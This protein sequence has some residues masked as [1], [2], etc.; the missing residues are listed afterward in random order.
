M[1]RDQ[2]PRHVFV[3]V[4]F[5]LVAVGFSFI[6]ERSAIFRRRKN[7]LDND[8]VALSFGSV[9]PDGNVVNVPHAGPETTLRL[10]GD[11][12]FGYF[13]VVGR[14]VEEWKAFVG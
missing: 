4:G 8:A 14:L 11:V 9:S 7:A 1:L 5:A 13:E 6:A 12:F 2:F 10:D 3:E